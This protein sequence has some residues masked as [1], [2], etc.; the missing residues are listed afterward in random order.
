MDF[1]ALLGSRNSSCALVLNSPELILCQ[2]TGELA[3]VGDER[4]AKS[5]SATVVNKTDEAVPGRHDWMI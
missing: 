2:Q 5:L 4:L 3:R 1:V